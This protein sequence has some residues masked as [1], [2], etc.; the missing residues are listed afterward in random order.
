MLIAPDFMIILAPESY[1]EAKNII[2]PV[3][4]SIYFM[5]LYSFFVNIEIYN[6]KNKYM[7]I[8]TF[9]AAVGNIVGNYVLIPV[10]GYKAA[11]YTTLFSYVLLMILHY[12]FLTYL[13]KLNIYTIKMFI[14]PIVF[15]IIMTT[16]SLLTLEIIVV[17]YLVMLALFLAGGIWMIVKK[18]YINDFI[19]S[20]KR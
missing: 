8:S 13:F 12:I 16:I 18:A 2:A 11:A 10:F 1:L 14:C 6:K 3:I 4:L 20:I 5:F 15:M 7:A 17:R 19:Y 9:I